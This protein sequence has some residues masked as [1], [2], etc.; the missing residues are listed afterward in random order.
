MIEVMA[1][2]ISL[3]LALLAIYLGGRWKEISTKI[4]LIAKLLRELA[5]VVHEISE[6][7]KDGK[8]TPEEL[9]DIHQEIENLLRIISEIRSEF[10]TLKLL[11]SVRH[12]MD[13]VKEARSRERG[14]RD[15]Q[16]S[17]RR[18]GSRKSRRKS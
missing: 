17:R 1:G 6:A 4:E 12:L 16:D 13:I 9:K 2:I 10:D 8:I 3:F 15:S 7:V 5:D 11:G 18:K 14:A